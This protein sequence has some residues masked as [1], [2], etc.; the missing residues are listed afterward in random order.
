MT[1]LYDLRIYVKLQATDL[2]EEVERGLTLLDA[3]ATRSRS[4]SMMRGLRS[5]SHELIHRL[6]SGSSNGS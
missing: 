1:C 2:A 4:S 5:K 3:P 6:S